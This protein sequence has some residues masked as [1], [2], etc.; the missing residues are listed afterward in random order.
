[1]NAQLEGSWDQVMSVVRSIH[2]ACVDDNPRV[3][4]TI[5]VIDDQ[6][7]GVSTCWPRYLDDTT[8]LVQASGRLVAP[9]ARRIPVLV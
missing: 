4:T 5:V 9:T 1:M 2:Q 7:G 3:V 6:A 8:Q